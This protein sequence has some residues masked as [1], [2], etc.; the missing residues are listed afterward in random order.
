MSVSDLATAPKTC[1]PPVSVSTLPTHLQVTFS[2]LATSNEGGIQSDRDRRRRRFRPDC[3]TIP[4]CGAGSQG[5]ATH[6]LFVVADAD[7]KHLLQ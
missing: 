2:V 5:V 6:G 7:R 4:K 1:R 3:G